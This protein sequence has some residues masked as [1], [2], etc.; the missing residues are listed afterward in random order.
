MM[1]ENKKQSKI[2]LSS[3]KSHPPNHSDRY[4]F[5]CVGCLSD[6]VVIFI[7]FPVQLILSP[8]DI[9]GE[10]IE[11]DGDLIDFVLKLFYLSPSDFFNFP[12]S[13]L[14]VLIMVSMILIEAL[15]LKKNQSISWNKSFLT[16][17]SGNIVFLFSYTIISLFL[18]MPGFS[19]IPALVLAKMYIFFNKSTWL[20]RASHGLFFGLSF[21]IIISLH[22]FMGEDKTSFI[23]YLTKFVV[24]FIGFI[25]RFVIKGFS[26]SLFFPRQSRTQNLA[27]TFWTMQVAILPLI[28]IAFYWTQNF[29][30]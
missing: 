2:L 8:W 27:S 23:F 13:K 26:Y 20:S 10:L 24:I 6:L 12:S 18:I 3:A 16:V 15:I 1:N 14:T 28:L 9:K 29:S 21:M 30:K 17:I 11:G 19:L 5:G 22:I 7:L 4:A 25:T